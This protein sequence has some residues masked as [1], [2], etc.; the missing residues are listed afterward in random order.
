MGEDIEDTSAI[1][2][3]DGTV[4][5]LLVGSTAKNRILCLRAFHLCFRYT[6]MVSSSIH[7]D[8]EPS[9]WPHRG[10]S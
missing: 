2:E 7:A 8:D 9:A 1:I 3:A 4:T 10:R 5:N 6:R